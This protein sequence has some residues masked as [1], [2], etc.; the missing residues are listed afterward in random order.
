MENRPRR[1]SL[2]FG[3]DPGKGVD[4]LHSALLSAILVCHCIT[5]NVR[6][7]KSNILNECYASEPRLA[8]V[9]NHGG[10]NVLWDAGQWAAAVKTV[11]YVLFNGPTVTQMNTPETDGYL[12]RKGQW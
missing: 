7:K 12:S 6:G 4:P 5:V 9:I 11:L 8:D 10:I 2:N 1:E 3:V